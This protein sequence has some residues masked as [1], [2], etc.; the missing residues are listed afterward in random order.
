MTC[1]HAKFPDNEQHFTPEHLDIAINAHEGTKNVTLGLILS[2][3]FLKI[4]FGQMH[5]WDAA[6]AE[7]PT[8]RQ[9]WF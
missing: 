6:P 3:V 9:L 8:L 1:T 5:N 7:R 4:R 2:F